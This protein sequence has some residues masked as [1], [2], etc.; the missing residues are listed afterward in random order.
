M[1]RESAQ[2]DGQQISDDRAKEDETGIAEL[3]VA[4]D[5]ALAVTLLYHK[6]VS[7]G[8]QNC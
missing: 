8:S 5:W 2:S 1:G 6:M 4:Q 7:A 3:G